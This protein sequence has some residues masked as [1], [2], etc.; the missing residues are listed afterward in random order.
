MLKANFEIKLPFNKLNYELKEKYSHI[1]VVRSDGA[2]VWCVTRNGVNKWLKY[3]QE[4][5]FK[6]LSIKTPEEK[7][8]TL[9]EWSKW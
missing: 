5:G 7:E 8:F 9:A 2:S 6:I 1:V 4:K 3:L